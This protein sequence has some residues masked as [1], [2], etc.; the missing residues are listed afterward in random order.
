GSD[1]GSS[2]GA[3]SVDACGPRAPT[4]TTSPTRATIVV[5]RMRRRPTKRF[6][7]AMVVRAGPRDNSH[8]ARARRS[9]IEMPKYLRKRPRQ[10]RARTT[11]GAIVEAAAR[12]LADEGPGALTTNRIALRAGV[13]IGS[14]YQYFPDR[15]AIVRALFERELARAEALRPATLDDPT[16]PAEERLRAAV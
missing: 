7:S 9:S 2:T 5:R 4:I 11:F 3:A 14:L 6:T 13:S 10:A 1:T 16:R 12:I 8:F 15:K